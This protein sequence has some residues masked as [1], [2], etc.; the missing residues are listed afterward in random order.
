MPSIG[1]LK[2][3]FGLLG[4]KDFVPAKTTN[5]EKDSSRRKPAKADERK[6]KIFILK[7]F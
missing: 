6:S 3:D 5:K 4:S 7:K 2:V 1:R